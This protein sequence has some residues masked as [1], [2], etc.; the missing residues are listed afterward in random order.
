[1]HKI[2]VTTD[3]AKSEGA[4]LSY[5]LKRI[6]SYIDGLKNSGDLPKHI[7]P[8]L[9]PKC[10]ELLKSL[11]DGGYIAEST[12]DKKNQKQVPIV[13]AP[14]DFGAR[15]SRIKLSVTAAEQEPVQPNEQQSTSFKPKIETN[16]V[17]KAKT[18][19]AQLVK[20]SFQI[21][22]K[23]VS[24]SFAAQVK[25]DV[26]T[27]TKLK[28]SIEMK[29]KDAQIIHDLEITNLSLVELLTQAYMQIEALKASLGKK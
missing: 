12:Q 6:L 24:P 18:D 8:S 26:D 9:R 13:K 17:A 21:S 22:E 11:L 20:E 5:D 10:N 14:P 23:Q 7:P 29:A 4:R 27:S 1:M 25:A 15:T 2:F 19:S 16:L 28:A 3:K